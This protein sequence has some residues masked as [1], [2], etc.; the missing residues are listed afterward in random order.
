MLAGIFGIQNLSIEKVNQ[1]ENFLLTEKIDGRTKI[2]GAFE[3]LSTAIKKSMGDFNFNYS[4]VNRLN[5]NALQTKVKDIDKSDSEYVK[6]KKWT[7]DGSRKIIEI[8]PELSNLQSRFNNPYSLAQIYNILK[9]DTGGFS[10]TCMTHTRENTYRS[11]IILGTNSALSNRLVADS[12]RPFDGQLSR[13]IERIAFTISNKKISQLENS[14]TNVESLYIPIVVEENKFLFAMDLAEIKRS[15]KKKIDPLKES[16]ENQLE[17][18][19]NKSERIKS[20]ANNICAYTGNL[21]VSGEIDHIIPRSYSKKLMGTT[22]NSEFNLLYVSNQGNQIKSNHLYTLNDLNE[23]YLLSIFGTTDRNK[24]TDTITLTMRNIYSS[25][26]DFIFH[27]LSEEEKNCVKF[28]LFIEDLRDITISLL[29]MTNKTKVN[30]TQAYLAKLIKKNLSS[31]LQK[32]KFSNYKIDIIK[33]N[34]DKVYEFRNILS[35]TYPQFKKSFPQTPGSH[36]IDATLAFVF[37]LSDKKEL[38]FIQSEIPESGELTANYLN[39]FLPSEFSIKSIERKA[40]YLREAKSIKNSPLF[41]DGIYAE[42]FLPLFIYQSKLFIGFSPENSIEIVKNPQLLFNSIFDYILYNRNPIKDLYDF[43]LNK[44]EVEN[45][46][47]YFEIDKQKSLL[48]LHEVAHSSPSELD[49]KKVEILDSFIYRTQKYEISS[50]IISNNKLVTKDELLKVANFKIKVDFE[51]EKK[52]K[53]KGDLFL[54]VRQEWQRLLNHPL[55]DKLYSESIDKKDFNWTELYT[56]FFPNQFPSKKLH[57][58]VRKKFSLPMIKSVSGGYRVKR[59]N[60]EGEIILQ[61]IEQKGGSN[62]GFPVKNNK[63]DLNKDSAVTNPAYQSKNLTPLD[64]SSIKNISEIQEVV[65]FNHYLNIE[66]PE[67]YVNKLIVIKCCPHSKTRFY[68]SV[69]VS[70]PYFLEYI[71]PY[72]ID[73]PHR[74][75]LNLSL[76]QIP[77]FFKLEGKNSEIFEFLPFPRDGKIYI[78]NFK[79]ESLCLEYEA[80]GKWNDEYSK[81][82]N[83]K[84][85]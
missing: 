84:F 28:S 21:I 48:F 61:L 34:S 19:K 56:S 82:F 60:K 7:D 51:L 41:N 10:K 75:E 63:I 2:M 39:S 4:R 45:R 5:N 16:L 9:G 27:S 14:L 77:D 69:I 83:K 42:N 59:K 78:T 53:I 38:Q 49:W 66:V 58:K 36:V 80:Q 33:I 71:Y 6:Y 73:V 43:W 29:G 81:E 17:Q 72:G 79:N 40:K 13:M 11:S 62:I 8:I 23:I 76:Y 24:I 64:L 44:S 22:L 25:R 68:F 55:I 20:S 85:S 47:V 35:E 1:L 67:I 12:V 30:G 74:G 31:Y 54:P 3:K 65:P 37:A 26:G 46:I 52:N 70:T 32:E 18:W 15:G 57:K 50:S